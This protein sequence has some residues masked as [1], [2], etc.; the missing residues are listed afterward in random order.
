[1]CLLSA[2][3]ETSP[4]DKGLRKG[5]KTAQGPTAKMWQSQ[6]FNELYLIE[7]SSLSRMIQCESCCPWLWHQEGTALWGAWVAQSVKRPTSARSRSRGP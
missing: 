1:M 5:E 6:N 2:S 7:A 4:F 3:T